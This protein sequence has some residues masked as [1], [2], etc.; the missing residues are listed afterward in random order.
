M[1]PL[2]SDR[3]N[4]NP[5]AKAMVSISS[6]WYLKELSSLAFTRYVKPPLKVKWSL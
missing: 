1:L 2:S 6:R 5:T 4:T 3:D